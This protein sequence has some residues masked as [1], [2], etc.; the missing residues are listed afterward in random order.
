MSLKRFLLGTA[1]G[2]TTASVITAKYGRVIRKE[3]NY[4]SEDLGD[5]LA[6]ITEET[7]EIREKLPKI[8]S[9]LN[10]TAAPIIKDIKGDIRDYQYQITPRIKEIK[11]KVN[12]LQESFDQLH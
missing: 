7:Q 6:E 3:I 4:L 1:L 10:T 5:Y 9:Y 2:F 12:D 8:Q 11:Q